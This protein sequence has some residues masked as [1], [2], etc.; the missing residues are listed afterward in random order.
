[1]IMINK[2]TTILGMV[3]GST[4]DKELHDFNMIY[5]ELISIKY[6]NIKY[7]N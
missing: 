3:G 2:G 4:G 6:I 7:M 1:M 5:V